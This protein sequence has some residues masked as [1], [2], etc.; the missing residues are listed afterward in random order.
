MKSVEWGPVSTREAVFKKVDRRSAMEAACVRHLLHVLPGKSIAVIAPDS[1]LLPPAL[2]SALSPSRLEEPERSAARQPEDIDYV[3]AD[4]RQRAFGQ[5]RDRL[6]EAVSRLKPG[7]ALAVFCTAAEHRRLEAFSREL[8]LHEI[9]S[10]PWGPPPLLLPAGL[11]RKLE[12]AF[13]LLQHSP[14]GG[15]LAR[16][17]ILTARRPGPEFERPGL[18]RREKL[19]GR[20]SA[21][22]PCH[23]EAMN[24]ERL[25]KALCDYYGEYWKE[26]V[27]VDDNSRDETAAVIARLA[28][29]DPRI[30][31]LRRRPPNGVGRALRDGYDAAA[32]DFILSMDCDFVELL[33]ELTD[34][35][36][37]VADGADGAIGSRFSYSSVMLGYPF[38]KM[39]CNRFFHLV[40]RLAT[41]LK[42][43]DISNNLKLYRRDVIRAISVE[44]PHFAANLET[45]LKPL[46]AGFNIVEVPV[47][48]IN[49]R[50]DMGSSSF[51]TLRVGPP[52]AA[53]LLR[54]LIS[55][56]HSADPR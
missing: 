2:K 45:G 13:F 38:G 11:T 22:I 50:A 19:K 47:S 14:L 23:N 5:L 32:G 46:L 44:E 40:L 54:T 16:R 24:I 10:A 56:P 30:K 28:A 52:Y 25:V 49:R 26:I 37:A 1:S 35:F 8:G 12:G 6:A 39:L 15:V 9:A 36:D 55:P 43:H 51:R 7:G 3:V 42:V 33:P 41:G 21:V 53:S 31:L 4:L 18:A 48:W 20:I 17:R 27:L 34:L 29:V